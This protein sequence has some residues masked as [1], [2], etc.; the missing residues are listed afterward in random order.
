MV[1]RPED[2][3]KELKVERSFF[4]IINKNNFCDLSTLEITTQKTF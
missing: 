1:I 4:L 3:V 2:Y